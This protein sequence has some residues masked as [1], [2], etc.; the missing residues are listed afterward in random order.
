MKLLKIQFELKIIKNTRHS[1]KVENKILLR[2]HDHGV[3]KTSIYF[4]TVN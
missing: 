1:G 3:D 2:I 4:S